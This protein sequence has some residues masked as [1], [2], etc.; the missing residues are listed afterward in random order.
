VTFLFKP[1]AAGPVSQVA[2]IV[3]GFDDENIER[4]VTLEGIGV[5]PV[6]AA[7]PLFLTGLGGLAYLSRR[8]KPA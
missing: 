4:L 5:V 7:L 2:R 3:F 8:R 6:P 1:T